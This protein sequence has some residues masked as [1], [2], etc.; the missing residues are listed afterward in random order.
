[1]GI[2][3]TTPRSGPHWAP[4]G[5]AAGHTD[6]TGLFAFLSFTFMIGRPLGGRAMMLRKSCDPHGNTPFCYLILEAPQI[7]KSPREVFLAEVRPPKGG[8]E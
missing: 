2:C 4:V 8:C 7:T 5:P 1:M 3:M 6:P